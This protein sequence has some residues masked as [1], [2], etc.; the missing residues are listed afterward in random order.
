MADSKEIELEVAEIVTE[1]RG[2]AV[3]AMVKLKGQRETGENP[4][5]TLGKDFPLDLVKQV[6]EARKASAKFYIKVS[7]V[8]TECPLVIVSDHS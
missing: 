6:A 8:G 7:V 4:Y 3:T 2:K 5:V 1:I